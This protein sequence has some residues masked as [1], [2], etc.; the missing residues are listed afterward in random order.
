MIFK[1]IGSPKKIFHLNSLAKTLVMTQAIN[2]D[3]GLIKVKKVAKDHF[4]A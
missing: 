4:T 3:A 1:K 2:V